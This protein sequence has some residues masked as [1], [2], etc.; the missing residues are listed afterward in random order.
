MKT[1]HFLIIIAI[2][3]YSCSKEQESPSQSQEENFYALTVGNSWVYKNYG[4]NSTTGNYDFINVIDSISIIGTEKINNHTYYRFRRMTTGNE[5]GYPLC[6]EN[7]EH[8]ELLR[9]SLGYLVTES[10][11]IRYSQNDYSERVYKDLSYGTI[12]EKLQENTQT[13]HVEAGSFN[14]LDMERYFKDVDDEQ[15]NGLDHYY[16]SN[17]IGLVYNTMSTINSPAPRF[18]RRLDSYS[19]Q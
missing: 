19:I 14:C 12:Y 8:F 4:L 5:I 7:G 2:V 13:I 1:Y 9:D 6:F 11:N 18:E 3:F 15:S 17:G 10:G 16:Y